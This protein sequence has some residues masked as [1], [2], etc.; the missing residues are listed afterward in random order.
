[1]A[2]QEALVLYGRL[3]T[4]P[5]LTYTSEVVQANLDAF[6]QLEDRYDDPQERCNRTRE[7]YGNTYWWY[8]YY[9]PQ[10]E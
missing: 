8:Y 7:L 5:R 6:V 9:Q 10:P 2:Y 3:H 1:M 4:H